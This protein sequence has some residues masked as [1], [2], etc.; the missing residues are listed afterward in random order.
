MAH[1]LNEDPIAL[2]RKWDGHP[3]RLKLYDRAEALPMWRGR[4]AAGSERGRFRRGVGVAIGHWLYLFHA[5]THVEVRA[6]AAGI[7]ATTASQDMGNGTR[8]VIARSVASVFGLSPSAI[9]VRLGDSQAPRGPMSAGSRTTASV[10]PAARK[11][12]EEVRDKLLHA[13]RTHFNL[14]DAAPA[15]GGIR[16]AGGRLAWG[17]ILNAVP[18]VSAIARRGRDAGM[19]AMPL[20]LGAD[21]IRTGRHFTGAVHMTEVEVDTRLGKIRPLRVWGGLTAGK[22]VVPELARSQ[23]YGGVIQGLGYALY[24]E[25]QTDMPTG[26]IISV[27]LE[28]YRIPGIGDTPEIEIAFLEEGFEHAQGGAVGLGELST[29][30]VAASVGNAVFNATGVRQYHLPIRPDRLLQS[31]GK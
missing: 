4:T 14:K 15:E 29:L 12:A 27:G 7:T 2:R 20:A 19:P 6:G 25:R 17:E 28:D 30:A 21:G 18:A 11:A 3:L 31:L 16:H 26:T 1:R 13:A 22:I 23:C 24:E 8:S 10:H 9:A 5:E